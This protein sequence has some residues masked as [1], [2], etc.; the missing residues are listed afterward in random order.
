[1]RNLIKDL[2]DLIIEAGV[3]AIKRRE[4]GLTI[5][6][7]EDKSP[8]TNVDKE[9]SNF[10]YNNLKLLRPDIPVICEEREVDILN[11]NNFWLI[12]PI[13]GT[14]S[15]MEGY[16]TYTV[17][18]AL[19]KEGVPVI[20]LVYHPSLGRL[21]YTDDSNLLRIEQDNVEI[22]YATTR[23]GDAGALISSRSLDLENAGLLEILPQD[24]GS[25]EV[26]LESID[27]NTRNFLEKH[28]ITK[29]TIVPSSIKL[30][31]IAEG[32]FDIYPRFGETMQWDIAA[33]H[34]LIKAGGGNVMDFAGNELIYQKNH[35]KNPNF[36]AYSKY[37]LLDKE[38]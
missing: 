11:D 10:I 29:A 1:M 34:A 22:S 8:V 23:E 26:S 15:Y 9:I 18:I 36:Y 30:C 28:L 4:V 16:N 38:V 6:Y 21:Y 5:S 2:R 33:G 37:W 27:F 3:I 32:K 20:G 12:D 35:Y 31:L 14:G 13:D 19:I 7:K 24:N 25:Y 17:N